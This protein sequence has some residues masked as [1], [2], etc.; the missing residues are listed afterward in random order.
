M[1]RKDIPHLSALAHHKGR[2]GNNQLDKQMILS[3][4]RV[5]L[6]NYENGLVD[7]VTLEV[8]EIAHAGKKRRGRLMLEVELP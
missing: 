7:V 2:E 8:T 6:D 3:T 1:T 5:L 4:G